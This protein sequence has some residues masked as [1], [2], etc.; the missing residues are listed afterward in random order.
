MLTET[1]VTHKRNGHKSML[2]NRQKSL[3]DE[4]KKGKLQERKCAAGVMAMARAQD[5]SVPRLVDCAQVF[6][7]RVRKTVARISEPHRTTQLC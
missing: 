7:F 4:Y 6:A 3:A 2:N 5:V 1:M